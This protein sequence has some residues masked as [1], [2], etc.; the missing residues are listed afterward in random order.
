MSAGEGLLCVLAFG[1]TV[2]CISPFPDGAIGVRW[3]L[4]SIGVPAL[5]I[6]S[7]TH[8]PLVAISILA[9]TLIWSP[10]PVGGLE[11][12]WG[13]LLLGLLVAAAPADLRPVYWAVGAGLA[14]NSIFA[15]LQ[16]AGFDPVS[17][18]G[19]PGVNGLFFNKMQQNNLI[20][21]AVIGLV[22]LNDWRA[23]ALAAWSSW[24]L[25]VPPQSRGALLAL[26]APGVVLL[27]RWRKLAAVAC[28]TGGLAM[29]LLLIGAPGRLPSN[30]ERVGTWTDAVRNLTPLG[31]GL[32]SFRW[33]YPEM[34][35]AHNDL[36]QITYELGFPGL[37]AFAALMVVALRAAGSAEGLILAAFLVEGLVG[38]PLYWPTTGFLAALCVG[39]ALRRRGLCRAV[40]SIE[41]AGDAGEGVAGPA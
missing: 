14:I 22:S 8:V 26:A 10:D 18:P 31:Y 39:A 27:W 33:S 36:L 6:I 25:F 13:L 1:V 23:W 38:F 15:A 41:R 37:A 30:L 5:A 7:R 16:F 3:A 21:L 4:L 28:G 17:H 2:A 19:E 40:V 20:A 32:G 12:W 34:E 24:P 35:F 29:L 11:V 9:S